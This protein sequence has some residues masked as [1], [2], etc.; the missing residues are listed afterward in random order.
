LRGSQRSL[1]LRNVSSVNDNA[2]ATK[3]EAKTHM[4]VK[5]NAVVVV[6][7]DVDKV[8]RR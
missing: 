8:H 5:L 6:L 7:W 1:R 2:R 3:E 4:I